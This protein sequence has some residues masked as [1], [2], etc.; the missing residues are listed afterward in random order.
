MTD[1]TSEPDDVAGRRSPADVVIAVAAI[2]VTVILFYID[3][4]QPRGVI[5]GIGYPAVVALSARFGRNP[6]LGTAFFCSLLIVGAHF[7]LPQ[8]GISLGGELAN[9]AF[10]LASLWIVAGV[11]LGR[12]RIERAIAQ[13][14]ATLRRLQ[15]AQSRIAR[16]ALIEDKP[17]VDRVRC[18]T[19][20]AGEALGADLTAVLR[21]YDNGTLVKSVDTYQRSTRK[22]F[23]L[24]DIRTPDSPTYQYLR[25]TDYVLPVRDLKRLGEFSSR[26]LLV[27]TMNIRATLTVGVLS[28]AELAGQVIFA[29]VGEPRTWSQEDIAFARSVGRFVTILFANEESEQLQERLRQVARMEAMGQMAGGVAHDFN[30]ILGAIMGF[31]GFLMQDLP[32]GEE[33]HMF[34]SRIMAAAERGKAQVNKVLALARGTDGTVQPEGGA[35]VQAGLGPP[36]GGERV[37]VVD[38]EPDIVDAM[39]IGLERLGYSPVGVSDPQEALA[40]FEEDPHAFDVVVTDLVMPSLR[41]SELIR[42]IKAIRPDI[43]AILCTA[44]SDGAKT[45]NEHTSVADASFHKPVNADAISACIQELIGRNRSQP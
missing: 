33:P 21:F 16:E 14:A 18:V 29:M 41:G 12:I 35:G 37:L 20:I 40:A 3:S 8:T 43:R 27:K 11:M 1:R 31:S 25:Q 39:V 19:E 34:A 9:R 4:T 24:M 36:K 17:F 38:D 7:L 45:G 5:D 10:G 42:R 44:Y 28:G 23:L 2:L 6:M 32:A 30:N 22:H 26:D 15:A 13:R